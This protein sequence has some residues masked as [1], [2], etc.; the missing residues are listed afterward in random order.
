MMFPLLQVSIW[1]LSSQEETTGLQEIVPDGILL[2]NFCIDLVKE[3]RKKE[4]KR[5]YVVNF[6]LHCGT[7]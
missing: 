3:I 6:I 5:K 1:R 4:K 2:A 7:F